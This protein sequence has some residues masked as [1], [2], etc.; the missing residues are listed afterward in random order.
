[1]LK[2][3]PGIFKDGQI[4]LLE[5]PPK[6]ARNNV[7]VTFELEESDESFLEEHWKAWDIFLE[8]CKELDLSQQNWRAYDEAAKRRP[9]FG[10]REIKW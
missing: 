10:G 4:H 3:I 6:G 5:D 2:L 1:M 8:S 7:V 9:F